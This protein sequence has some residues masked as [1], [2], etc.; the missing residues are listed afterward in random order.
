MQVREGEGDESAEGFSNLPEHEGQHRATILSV[1]RNVRDAP[2]AEFMHRTRHAPPAPVQVVPAGIWAARVKL[3]ALA[4]ESEPMMGTSFP[5]T[6][7]VTVMSTNAA[8]VP[9]ASAWQV[10]GP[11]PS[12]KWGI[13]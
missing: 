5:G 7:C 3:V 1:L 11:A 10:Y 9:V 4:P 13:M 12:S 8:P 6:C 2:M